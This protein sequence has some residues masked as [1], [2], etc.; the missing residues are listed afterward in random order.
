[1][2]MHRA[3][4]LVWASCL[5]LAAGGVLGVHGLALA[6]PPTPPYPSIGASGDDTTKYDLVQCLYINGSM[7]G[8][9]PACPALPELEEPEEDPES[10]LVWGPGAPQGGDMNYDG[11][12]CTQDTMTFS[13]AYING[14][15]SADVNNDG[16]IDNADV[17]HYFAAIEEEQ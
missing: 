14:H 15:P 3:S 4:Q 17:L 2:P 10:M 8:A 13:Q 7:V 9:S 11:W 6:D 12:H 5:A 1:M 16:V